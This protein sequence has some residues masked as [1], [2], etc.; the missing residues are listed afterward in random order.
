[1][2]ENQN[3]ANRKRYQR[4]LESPD[5]VTPAEHD[6]FCLHGKIPGV[7]GSY[8]E[9]DRFFSCPVCV[10]KE[11]QEK[12]HEEIEQKIGASGIGKRYYAVEW[13]N[14]ELLEPMNRVRASCEN[15]KSVLESGA[16]AIFWG[17]PGS[18][19]TQSAIMSVKSAIRSTRTAQIVNLG[20]LCLDIRSSYASGVLSESEAVRNLAG[21]DLMVFDD[22]GAGE[23]GKGTL[24]QRI[25][26]L[27]LEARQN[28]Q[29][30]TII[31]T[32]LNPAELAESVGQRI[33][34]RLQPLSIVHFNHGKNFR[35]LEEKNHAGW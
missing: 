26:Y 10:M 34:N 4:W 7:L 20:R 1:M 13:E 23:T 24:E 27:V 3:I 12:L 30:S 33:V 2:D 9:V 28:E 15:I 6:E 5:L 8:Y 21:T 11:K 32:N 25:L 19:K 29:K 35:K 14:L 16:N 22:L 18:G 31:T 17:A